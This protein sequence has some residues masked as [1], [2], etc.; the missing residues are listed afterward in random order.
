M[1]EAAAVR[2]ISEASAYDSKFQGF[3]VAGQIIV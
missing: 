2:D 3:L 1:V